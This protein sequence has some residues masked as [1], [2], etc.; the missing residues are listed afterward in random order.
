[1]AWRVLILGGGVVSLGSISRTLPVPGLREHAVGFKTLPDA[2][3]LHNRVLQSMEIAETLE[4]PA[5]RRACLTYVFVGATPA[6][7][8]WPSSRTW[9]WTPSSATRAAGSRACAG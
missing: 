1:M 9:R 3:A 4:D 2:I 8:V 6:W 5:E 7:R